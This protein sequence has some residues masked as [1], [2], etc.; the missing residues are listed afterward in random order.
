MTDVNITC[1]LVSSSIFNILHADKKK[2][3]HDKK[4]YKKI[5]KIIWKK[6]KL[7]DDPFKRVLDK[8][9]VKNFCIIAQ[10][11]GIRLYDDIDDDTF[12][13]IYRTFVD[14]QVES[15]LKDN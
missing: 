15:L 3:E 12:D 1:M 11:L 14:N 6:G 4:Y 2:K 10:K 5:Y 8:K 13:I 7:S 9:L